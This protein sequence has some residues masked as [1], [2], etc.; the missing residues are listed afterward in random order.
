MNLIDKARN[1]FH[2]IKSVNH[3]E[4]LRNGDA[5]KD[6]CAAELIRYTHAIEKGLSIEKPR[7]GFGHQ[8]QEQMLLLLEKLKE[9]ND[10]YHVEASQMAVDSIAAYIKYHQERNYID[11]MITKLSAAIKTWSVSNNSPLGGVIEVERES[12]ELD[13]NA[14]ETLFRTR[15]SIRDFDSRE[16]NDEEL[17]MA[18]ELAQRAPSACNRQGYRVYVYSRE[19]S[20]E[21][22]KKLAGIGGFEDVVTRYILIT[23]KTS[24]YRYDEKF[25]YIV[26]ASMYAAYLT[27]TLHLFGMGG[28]PVQRPVIW[29]D[30]WEETR[31]KYNIPND[32]QSVLLLAVGNLKDRTTVPESHRLSPGI[33]FRFIN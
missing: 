31:K 3:Y 21:Y 15:H 28:V 19:K 8:K 32:E 9:S 10:I 25:Q 13:Q 26:S 27:L 5:Y 33:M 20:S 11:D 23:G 30:D 14:I 7:L 24:A 17:K 12:F 4:A 1:Y 16:I 6:F 29:D 22:A 2:I 18:L